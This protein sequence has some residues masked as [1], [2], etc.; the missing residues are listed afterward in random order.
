[1]KP[2]NIELPPELRMK[3]DNGDLPNLRR[4]CNK[5]LRCEHYD[6]IMNFLTS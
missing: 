3:R 2:E 1:M 4:M 5:H 6:E